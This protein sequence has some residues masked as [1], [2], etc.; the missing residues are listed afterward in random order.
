[1][2]FKRLFEYRREPEQKKK[3]YLCPASAGKSFAGLAQLV[4]R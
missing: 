1:M 3:C 2:K 4:E